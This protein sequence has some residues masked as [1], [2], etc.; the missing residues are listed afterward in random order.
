MAWGHSNGT[1]HCIRVVISNLKL[2]PHLPLCIATQTKAGAQDS[3]GLQAGISRRRGQRGD[4][5][6]L[7]SWH[8]SR[9]HQRKCRETANFYKAGS[10]EA[11]RPRCNDGG[12][13]AAQLLLAALH[14]T[15]L[16]QQTALH[17]TI[18]RVC[19]KGKTHRE[20]EGKPLGGKGN[21]HHDAVQ[22]KGWQGRARSHCG[23]RVGRKGR[24]GKP[25]AP[26]LQTESARLIIPR[27][28]QI[29]PANL[30]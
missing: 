27:T 30:K 12:V 26:A 3:L 2:S 1:S 28:I 11:P 24:W 18:K 4:K 13:P 7:L 10:G 20:G 9:Q 23:T 15:V 14:P 19:V 5:K 16:P 6:G 8:G 17:P 22:S 21:Q 25:K 29:L